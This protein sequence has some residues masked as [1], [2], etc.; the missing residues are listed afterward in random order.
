MQFQLVFQYSDS[1]A[2]SIRDM[3]HCFTVTVV[4]KTF[5]AMK[6]VETNSSSHCVSRPSSCL[7]RRPPA[8][9]P[10]C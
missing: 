7:A 4:K 1:V 9:S 2:Y 10:S 3:H 5:L 8:P 6:K